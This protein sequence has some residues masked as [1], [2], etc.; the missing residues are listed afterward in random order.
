MNHLVRSAVMRTK[1]NEKRQN[2]HTRQQWKTERKHTFILTLS[3]KWIETGSRDDELTRSSTVTALENAQIGACLARPRPREVKL[4]HIIHHKFITQPPSVTGEEINNFFKDVCY[5]THHSDRHRIRRKSL[6]ARLFRF[7]DLNRGP[8]KRPFDWSVWPASYE[9]NS[10]STVQ[11]T[12]NFSPIV[13]KKTFFPLQWQ[14]P[15]VGAIFCHSTT[16]WSHFLPNFT[17][18]YG[19]LQDETFFL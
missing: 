19:K 11:V 13:K 12:I 9:A 7:S 17:V 2:A 3:R 4:N 14:I 5:R 8:E 15:S 6:C 1:E 10:A 18:S 16:I